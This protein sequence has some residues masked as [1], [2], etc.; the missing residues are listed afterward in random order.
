MSKK[1][2][3]GMGRFKERMEHVIASKPY[4]RRFLQF[5]DAFN[6]GWTLQSVLTD[7]RAGVT[8]APR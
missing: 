4:A 7:V 2:E 3:P 6:D 5:D 1:L 8:L